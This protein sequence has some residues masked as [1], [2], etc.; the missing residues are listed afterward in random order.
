MTTHSDTAIPED[1]EGLVWAMLDGQISEDE[2]GRLDALLR[3]DEEVRRLYLQCVQLHV[4]L[5]DFYAATHNTAVQS[6]IGIPLSVSLPPGDA[7]VADPV[8]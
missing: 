2:L 7:S 5:V 4:D 8:M 3:D 6:P 1:L